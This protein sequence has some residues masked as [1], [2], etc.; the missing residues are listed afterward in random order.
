MSAK[1]IATQIAGVT[2]GVVGAGLIVIALDKASKP[3]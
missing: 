3:R 1:L 2:M